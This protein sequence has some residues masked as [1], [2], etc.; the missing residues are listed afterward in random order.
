MDLHNVD[1]EPYRY[2]GTNITGI[3]LVDPENP[4]LENWRKILVEPNGDY[5]ESEETEK[6]ESEV[7][8]ENRKIVWLD[9]RKKFSKFFSS[10]IDAVVTPSIK[11]ALIFDGVLLLAETFKQFEMEQL[12]AKQLTCNSNEVWESGNSISNFMRNVS[13]TK[14]KKKILIWQW[15]FRLLFKA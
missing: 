4:L 15:F 14:F 5:E 9:E 13:S 10:R 11:S 12:E 2:G 6:D 3:R 1:L 8:S 7:E